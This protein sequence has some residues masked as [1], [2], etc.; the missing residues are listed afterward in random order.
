MAVGDERLLEIKI[1]EGQDVQEI[2]QDIKYAHVALFMH[3]IDAGQILNAQKVQKAQT[4]KKSLA[5]IFIQ[6]GMITLTQ[7]QIG[8][9]SCRERV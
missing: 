8:R 9:A 5:D 4:P 7:S 2:V 6:E 1:Q 3:L